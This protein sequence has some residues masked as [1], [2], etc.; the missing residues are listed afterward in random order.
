MGAC[1]TQRGRVADTKHNEKAENKRRRAHSTVRRACVCVCGGGEASAP[2]CSSRSPL[3]NAAVTSRRRFSKQDTSSSFGL[4]SAMNGVDK[5]PQMVHDA[6]GGSTRTST[7]TLPRTMP[8][9]HTHTYARPHMPA[10]GLR[11][12]ANKRHQNTRGTIRDCSRKGKRKD[13]RSHT[14]Q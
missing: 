13:A 3:D 8:Q 7:S 9:T 1:S 6:R 12:T 5:R 4:Q 14:K 10:R 2:V 11:N